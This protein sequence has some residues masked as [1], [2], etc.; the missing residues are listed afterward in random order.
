M[1]VQQVE[2]GVHFKGR[3]IIADAIGGE[4]ARAGISV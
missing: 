4:R 2:V 1:K 3:E